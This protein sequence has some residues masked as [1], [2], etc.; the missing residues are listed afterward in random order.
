ML[1]LPFGLQSINLGLLFL[2][3]H[4][5][6]GQNRVDLM[7]D[8]AAQHNVGTAAGHVGGN[9]HHSQTTGFQH[10]LGFALMLLGIQNV[11]CDAFLRKELGDAL[12]V[13][14]GAG[15]KRRVGASIEVV[16]TSTG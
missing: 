11:V 16:P 10:H 12:G 2:G 15:K 1:H 14:P 9:R 8:A 6:V 13:F 5:I 7:I 3:A 4:F